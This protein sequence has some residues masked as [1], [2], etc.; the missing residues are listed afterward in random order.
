MTRKDTKGRVLRKGEY[1]QAKNNRYAYRHKDPCTGEVSWL[2]AKSLSE[3]RRREDEL[4]KAGSAMAMRDGRRTNLDQAFDDWAISREGDVA[5]GLLRASVLECYRYFWNKY[6]RGSRLGKCSVALV[7]K[8]MIQKHYKN[9]LATGLSAGTVETLHSLVSK[10]LTRASEDGLRADNPAR[11]ACTDITKAARARKRAQVGEQPRC[12]SPAGRKALLT[13]LE[14]ERWR[15]YAPI[16]RL[17]LHTGLRIGEICGLTEED[18]DQDEIRV[19]RSLRYATDARGHMGF[20]VNPPK[21]GTSRRDLPLSAAAIADVAAWQELGVA[22]ETQPCGLK[23]LVYCTPRRRALTYAA[24]NKILRKIAQEVNDGAGREIIPRNI[25]S[26]FLRHTFIT[27]A[28]E[29]G[30]S[31]IAVSRYVGHAD[32]K[33]TQRVYY[34]CRPEFLRASV[35]VLDNIEHYAD[36]IPVAPSITPSLPAPQAPSS[37]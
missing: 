2:Y 14:D 27:E 24:V 4:Q 30:M 35:D 17:Q 10:T 34:S 16:I 8:A 25:S 26:H 33:I 12:L 1:E 23:G 20:V 6:V 5:A 21:T 31:L 19:R 28:I 15:H 22:C 3:L 36:S 32:I 7:D 9:M 18:V 11:G 37:Y 29:S 13:A